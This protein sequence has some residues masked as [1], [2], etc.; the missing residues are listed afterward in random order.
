MT[1]WSAL[2]GG[3]AGTIALTTTLAGASHLGLTRM[4]IPLREITHGLATHYHMD[5]AGSAQDLKNR[6]MRLIVT[7]E[8]EAFI[9]PM[10]AYMK[11]VDAY[12]DI[13]LHDNVRVSCTDSR[14]FLKSLGFAGEIVHTPGHSDDSVSL[15]LDTG[16]C[17]TGDL[18]HP[19]F[20]TEE[21][22]GRVA[23][24]W[25]L[26]RSLGATAVH[27]GHGPVRQLTA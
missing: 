16:A 4:D 25:Q 5:H 11:E 21:M 2:A 19:M 27:A 10:K 14:A 24:S 6:G 8:Q 13:A 20:A 18:T 12:T 9:A 23:N 22:A 3:F 17:F 7:P 15:V 26:L 1:V